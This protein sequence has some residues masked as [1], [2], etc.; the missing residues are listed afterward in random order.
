MQL[1]SRAQ[2]CVHAVRTKHA[3]T[4]S[5]SSVLVSIFV[6]ETTLVKLMQ[7]CPPEAMYRIK[8]WQHLMH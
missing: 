2:T 5:S 6:A 8:R 7:S 4:A 3:S 1:A